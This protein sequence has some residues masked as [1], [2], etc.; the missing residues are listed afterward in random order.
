VHY[1]TPRGFGARHGYSPA[2]PLEHSYKGVY[3]VPK[4]A[5]KGSLDVLSILLY[6]TPAN[7]AVTTTGQQR[8]R[9]EGYNAKLR[10]RVTSPLHT[11]VV[12][13]RAGFEEAVVAPGAVHYLTWLVFRHAHLVQVSCQLGQ[14]PTVIETGC[15]QLVDSLT[16]N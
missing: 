9:I 4:S 7:A 14:R 6:R 3:L 5:P 10:V 15:V 8:Q 13:G 16:I 11:E 2:V 12:G 1:R